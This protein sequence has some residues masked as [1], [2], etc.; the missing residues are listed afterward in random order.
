MEVSCVV[1][2]EQNNFCYL[3]C[4]VS[5][6]STVLYEIGDCRTSARIGKAS[7]MLKL[8]GGWEGTKFRQEIGV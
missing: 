1:T 7:E 6:A 5:E 4:L 8:L 2:D 3:K